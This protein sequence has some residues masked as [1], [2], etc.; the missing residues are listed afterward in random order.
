MVIVSLILVDRSYSSSLWTAITRPN[1]ALAVV[2]TIVAAVL[3]LVLLLPSARDLFKF[4][5][6]DASQLAI[7]LGAGVAVLLALETI[8]PLWRTAPR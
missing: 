2:L 4:G 3:A 8:K 7:A 6:L 1:R 5:A